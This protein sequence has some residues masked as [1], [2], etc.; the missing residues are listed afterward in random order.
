ME[1]LSLQVALSLVVAALVLLLP[2]T[3]IYLLARQFL[4]REQ[5]FDMADALLAGVGLSIAFWPILLLY[6]SLVGLSFSPVYLWVILAICAFYVSYR[7]VKGPQSAIRNGPN[8][9]EGEAPLT[10]HVSRFTRSSTTDAIALLGMTAFSLAFRL[11]DIQGLDVPLFGD[12]LHHTM[13]TNIILQTGRLP[14]GYLPYVPVDTFTYH[15]GFH[16]LSAVLAAL[17]GLSA[18]HAV[19][20]MGQVL[21]TLAVP[22][23]Y[24]LG[25]QL[26]GSRIAGLGAA[27][28]AGFV[29]IMPAF[30][31]NWGRY[32]QLAGNLLLVITLVFIVRAMC[33][34]WR[35]SDIALA[36]FCV[37][38]L[39]VVHYRVLIFFGLFGLA[40]GAYQLFSRWG[41]WR[42]LVEGW[43]RG[44]IA[45]FAGL[46]LTFLWLLNIAVNYFPSLTRRLQ[47]VTPD[48]LAGYN[49]PDSIRL[50]LGV[51][52]PTVALVSVTLAALLYFKRRSNETEGE[53]GL[54]PN[55]AV[56][57]LILWIGLLVGSLWPVPGAIGSY[58]VAISLYIPVAALGGYGIALA[59]QLLQ[60]QNRIKLGEPAFALVLLVAAPILALAAGTWHIADPGTYSSVHDPD[61]QAFAWIKANTPPTAKFLISSTFS[62]AGRGLTA[63]DAGMWLPLL[64]DRNVSI[65]ALSAW[66]EHPIDPT[67][68]TDTRKLAAY[69]QPIG[70]PGQTSDSLQINLV[71]KSVI[72][73]TANLSSPQAL[74]L[75]QKL[76][77]THV[78]S[79]AKIGNSVPRL[80]IEALRR[81]TDHYHLIYFKNGVYIFEVGI[82]T[83]LSVVS[84]QYVSRP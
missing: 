17:A 3:A 58:A 64:A 82:L 74:A 81:D 31:V 26:F 38:G 42:E 24:A 22:L 29:S 28:L 51:A 70:Q 60:A 49:N 56:V 40:L 57:V 4:D 47:T 5:A 37:G 39:M 16:T 67:F 71:K 53:P 73:G 23:A 59:V 66:M 65:P 1:I 68:F 36:A 27:L 35:R 32:T 21:I 10:F 44:L 78:Y 7:F 63:S 76:G 46:A 12:S 54:S 34:G 52:L 75:M 79:S 6:T 9:Q 41:H 20:F 15:F 19:L 8:N 77:I 69:T 48:Y 30:Y 33:N 25:R 45:V 61:E 55:G 50:F 14:T 43:A 11:G 84:C 18:P 13:I 83:K 2:G 72:T 80:D 62:Y